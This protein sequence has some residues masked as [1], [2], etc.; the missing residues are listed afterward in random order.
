MG[1]LVVGGVATYHWWPSDRASEDL[2]VRYRAEGPATTD[3]AKPWLE[4]I[5]TSG[6][7]VDLSD[8]TL[9]YHYTPDGGVEYAANCVQASLDCSSVTLRTAAARQPGA[10]ADRY[11][12][13][14]F[15]DAAGTLKPGGTTEGLGLQLYRLDH[16]ELDQSDDYSFD[17]AK[18]TYQ[19]SERVTAYLRGIQ[20]WGEGPGGERSWEAGPGAEAAPVAV[21]PPTGV[22]FDD[23]AYTGPQDPALTANGWVARSGE[24]GPGI[25]GSWS[26]KGVTFPAV[27]D[28]ERGQVLCLEART[29]GTETGTVQS[30][31][32]SAQPLF[33]EG[34]LVARVHFSDEP[35]SGRDGDHVSQSVFAISLDHKSKK[36][37]ELDFEYMPNG[38]WG[39]YGPLLDTTSW[40]SSDL[41]DRVTK[42]HQRK[43][44]GWRTL[45]ITAIDGEVTYSVDGQVVFTSGKKHYP[46]ESMSINFSH[47]FVDLPFKGPRSWEM[48]VDW[49]YVKSGEAISPDGATKA[50][51]DFAAEGVRYV[52]TLPE[53]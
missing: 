25:D 6:I 19:E 17:A 9:R 4:I 15:T 14:G 47:W 23:F 31:F 16:K 3:V 20:V 24:G 5:N 48:E 2:T 36:Y 7:A 32:H 18:T 45:A 35:A 28:G 11:L 29:D 39:R 8:V 13:V 21:Q 43:L 52:N 49:L 41:G 42:P 51:A 10:K 22:L 53:E 33:R 37:S 34:T 27:G 40:R 38:G 44:G 26:P 30:E 50:A 1:F 46:R 12:E